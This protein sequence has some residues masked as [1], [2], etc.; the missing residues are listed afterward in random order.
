MAKSTSVPPGEELRGYRVKLYPTQEQLHWLGSC[1]VEL[2]SAWNTLVISR[3]TH[4][5]HCV[6]YAE[7]H[8]L[9]GPVPPRPKSERTTNIPEE[10]AEWDEY[11]RLCGLRRYEAVRLTRKVEGLTWDE[12]RVD[13]KTL[14]ELFGGRESIASAQMYLSLVDTFRKTKGPRFKRRP[15]EM[16]LLNKTGG[17][18]I[19]LPDDCA[20]RTT[21]SGATRLV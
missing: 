2:M 19:R 5:E 1:Q 9:I 11:E 8:E 17:H 6:R 12:W 18:A 13:Y 14:R 7:D 10:I 4:V 16:P 21:A 20:T 3:E 15:I